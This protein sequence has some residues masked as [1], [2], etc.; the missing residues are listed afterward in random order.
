MKR[1]KLFLLLLATFLICYAGR[2]SAYDTFLYLCTYG[3]GTNSGWVSHQYWTVS[4]GYSDDGQEH[5]NITISEAPTAFL[6]NVKCPTQIIRKASTNGVSGETNTT[7]NIIGLD[8][9][10]FSYKDVTSVTLPP[11]YKSIPK[12]AFYSCTFLAYVDAPG[13][14]SIGESAFESSA[15]LL[16]YLKILL[17]LEIMPS[18]T[19]S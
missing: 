8:D 12:K 5:N 11:S 17:R 2:A 15:I 10:A 3:D 13:V 7:Y 16:H 9:D 4:G 14:T 19:R 6:K 1:R 18:I